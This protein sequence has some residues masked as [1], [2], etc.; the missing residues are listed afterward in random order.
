[1]KREVG[2]GTQ[3]NPHLKKVQGIHRKTRPAFS[4]WRHCRDPETRLNAADEL[5]CFYVPPNRC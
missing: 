5:I 1:M 2:A 3:N 4:T